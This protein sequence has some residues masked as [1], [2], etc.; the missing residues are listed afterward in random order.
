[1]APKKLTHTHN[2]LELTM[3]KAALGK[4][5][6]KVNSAITALRGAGLGKIADQ[7]WDDLLPLVGD[8]GD[9]G[10]TT[11]ERLAGLIGSMAADDAVTLT[12]TQAE[13][14]AYEVGLPMVARRLR[15]ME[16]ELRSLGRDDVGE[17]CVTT[18]NHV[19]SV[20]KDHYA[21]QLSH[22]DGGKKPA[23]KPAESRQPALV[24]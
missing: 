22:G 9:R 2:R 3:L 7:Q 12:S 1:M 6:D 19:G 4:Y 11:A 21:E 17:W 8:V 14:H 20:L 10:G 16:G 24:P 13:A 23:K 15:T 5:A 18:A